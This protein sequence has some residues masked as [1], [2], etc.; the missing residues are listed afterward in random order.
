MDDGYY[1][2]PHDFDFLVGRWR[3][4]S[5]RLRQRHVGSN[6][7]NEFEGVMQAWSHLDGIVSVDQ[8]DF[9][10]QGFSGCTVRT[11]DLAK[12]EWSICWVNSR[13]GRLEPPVRGGWQVD[14]GEFYGNDED[15]GRPVK[16]RFIWLRKGRDAASWEQSFSI[17]GGRN[18]EINWVMELQ[19][20]E[21]PASGHPT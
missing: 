7:W 9:E 17:D 14:R 18:W 4:H 11:L 12:R 2:R 10:S 1:G 20:W 13:S 19:R 15:D 16:V 6:D 5:R 8:F 3:V 21:P